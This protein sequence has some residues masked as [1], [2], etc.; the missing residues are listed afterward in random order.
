MSVLIDRARM[1]VAS[2][3]GTGTIALGAAASGQLTLAQAGVVDGQTLPYGIKDGA[4]WEVGTGTYSAA[5]PTLTRGAEF[6]SVGGGAITAG[7]AAVVYLTLVGPPV[8]SP[9]APPVAAG[10]IGTGT[11]QT[12]AL[13][14]SALVNIL[15]SCPSPTGFILAAGVGTIAAQN[16]DAFNPGIIYPPV[17][18]IINAL[19]INQ[20]Y[21][22]AVGAP[23]VS[24][25]TDAP[26]SQ[27]WAG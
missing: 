11:G 15:A 3:P 13:P 27:W 9:P 18:A 26:A 25:S 20:A 14:I 4:A 1:S 24:F 16:Q 17:G 6:S 2:A 8:P 7:A 5:G 10:L 19:A 22:I 23:R 12:T 21:S